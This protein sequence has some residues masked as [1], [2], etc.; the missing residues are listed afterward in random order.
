MWRMFMPHLHYPGSSFQI[1]S[2]KGIPLEFIAG[3]DVAIT[4]RQMSENNLLAAALVKK[5]GC[6]YIY[7][8]DDDLWH[9]PQWSPA[10][11][12]LVRSGQVRYIVEC[13]K[14]ADLIT[15]STHYLGSLVEQ[16]GLRKPIAVVENAIDLALFH[17]QRRQVDTGRVTI[18]W[19]GSNT[20]DRDLD[21]I[22]NVVGRVMKNNPNVDFEAMTSDLP[23]TFLRRIPRIKKRPFVNV[24]EY[25]AWFSNLSW[26]IVLAPLSAIQF[27]RSKSNIRLLE[28]GALGAAPLASS[29]GTYASFCSGDA[30]RE[31]ILCRNEDEWY[32]KLTA[33]VNEPERRKLLVSKVMEKVK[34]EYLIE[35]NAA[36]WVSLIEGL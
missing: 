23:K 5:V 15:V 2:Q 24:K 31:W 12:L 1:S 34:A 7:D 35:R 11:D 10:Y 4:Q 36:H 8:L 20:H 30:D 13:M 21:E 29:V 27:N 26:D 3:H 17:R 16:L 22:A 19:A 25:P 28:A 6:K 14:Y 9:I 33:L 32:K 18:G